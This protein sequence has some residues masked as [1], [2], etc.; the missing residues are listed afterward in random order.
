MDDSMLSMIVL[1]TAFFFTNSD[2]C[3]LHCFVL[4]ID[5]FFCRCLGWTVQGGAI[6]A[7]R[8]LYASIPDE[9]TVEVS[10]N[11]MS[12]GL[13]T[14]GAPATRRLFL[15]HILCS[16]VSLSTSMGSLK[17]LNVIVHLLCPQVI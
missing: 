15:S 16:L 7:L 14:E 9:I 5:L 10:E 2:R 13:L 3:L 1:Y 4:T 17:D 8:K 6:H 11:S 12:S